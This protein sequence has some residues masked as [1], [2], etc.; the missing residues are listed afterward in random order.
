MVL[1]LR[2]RIIS[3]P[4][5]AVWI[6]GCV[7]LLY[8][9]HLSVGVAS[10]CQLDDPSQ[11]G[12]QCLFGGVCNHSHADW[13]TT[14]TCVEQKCQ[15]Y[16]ADLCRTTG[17]EK[18]DLNVPSGGR[19]V[20]YSQMAQYYIHRHKFIMFLH[21][22]PGERITF[23]FT[24]I[25]LGGNTY[26]CPQGE[27]FIYDG[28]SN[29]E[30]SYTMKY[31]TRK[32]GFC[33]DEASKYYPIQST[34]RH[35]A[36]VF[37][38]FIG[39]EQ[40]KGFTGTFEVTGPVHG[41]WGEWSE[42]SKCRGSCIEGNFKT[43]SRSRV[44]D[45]PKPQDG[46][47]PCDGSAKENEKCDA[48]LA[49]IPN[50]CARGNYLGCAKNADCYVPEPKQGKSHLPSDLVCKCKNS[51]CKI[52]MEDACVASPTRRVR[53]VGSRGKIRSQAYPHYRY[54]EECEL[55]VEVPQAQWVMIKFN[56][57][58]MG[59]GS[60]CSQGHLVLFDGAS[61]RNFSKRYPSPKGSGFC[62]EVQ[63]PR[64]DDKYENIVISTGNYLTVF[65]DT[66]KRGS[67]DQNI[68][69]DAEFSSVPPGY[70]HSYLSELDIKIIAFSSMGGIFVLSV[71]AVSTWCYLRHRRRRKRL[72]CGSRVLRA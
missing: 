52:F 43:K 71:I 45:N 28:L 70:I 23:K 34:D 31:P 5:T 49:C 41:V 63:P 9:V 14:C 17:L 1:D 19:G 61:S 2:N 13:T 7:I 35:M 53:L 54:Q 12:K 40:R 42:W 46:G 69:F 62:S 72:R 26:I 10:H 48:K 18:F 38:S 20:I 32:S 16:M 27:V 60:S 33:G 51:D 22:P 3:Q 39:T 66:K 64:S 21:A 57:F 47:R 29:E 37:R 55:T 50:V 44:C 25:D 65:M 4:K 15:V 36:I 67:D 58:D 24:D 68:G 56:E 6:A 30:G 11:D 8:S 59:G